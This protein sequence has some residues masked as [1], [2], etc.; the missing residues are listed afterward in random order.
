MDTPTNALTIADGFDDTGDTTASPLRGI[1]FRF[2]DGSYYAYSDPFPTYDDTADGWQKL[3]EGCPPEYLM[4]QPGQMRPQRPH[5][6]E[7]DWPLDFN[8]KPDHPWKLTRYLYLMDTKT[9]EIST[10]W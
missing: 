1:A 3:A 10:F 5:V 9:G 8:G 4:R 7:K 2:K 6:D